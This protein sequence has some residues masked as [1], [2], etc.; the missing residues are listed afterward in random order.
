MAFAGHAAE[1]DP[2]PLVDFDEHRIV[3]GAMI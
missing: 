1:A 2:P 3:H